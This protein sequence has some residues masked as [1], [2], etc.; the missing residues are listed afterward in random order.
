MNL[1]T[2][3]AMAP[4]PGG[5]GGE[6][7]LMS[8]MIMLVLVF[9]IMY[10]MMIRPQQKRAKQHQEMIGALKKGDKVVLS[11]GVHG[12]I[13][14]T[15]EKTLLVQIADNVKVKVERNA[16]SS[17]VREADAVKDAK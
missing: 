5:G 7:G 13:A 2:I 9:G 12:T 1:Q 4:P 15:E 14:G 6:G 3:L 17:V 16:V 11:G 10:F 8:T